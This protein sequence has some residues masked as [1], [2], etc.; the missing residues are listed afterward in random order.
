[1]TPNFSIPRAH[2]NIL[3][4]LNITFSFSFYILGNITCS[5]STCYKSEGVVK[6]GIG[7]VKAGIGVVKAGIGVGKKG[8]GVE[9]TGIG[10]GKKGISHGN[11]VILPS[12]HMSI[13]CRLRKGGC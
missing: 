10:V 13:S 12:E 11:A 6:T 8:I 4:P 9:K 3:L 1:M 2:E 5:L 7:V